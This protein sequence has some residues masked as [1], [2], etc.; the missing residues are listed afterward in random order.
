MNLQLINMKKIFI[1]LLIVASFSANAQSKRKLFGLSLN[2][3]P[4]LDYRVAIG[5]V[6]T[7]SENMTMQQLLDF[8]TLNLNVYS[9]TEVD[10][11]F[12]NYLSKTNLIAYTPTLDTHPAT[13]KY[14]DEANKGQVSGTSGTTLLGNNRIMHWFTFTS[15]D[16]GPQVVPFPFPFPNTC[17]NVV[18]SPGYSNANLILTKDNFTYDRDNTININQTIYVQAIGR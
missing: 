8:T 9:K 16:D 12:T 14:A 10:N 18:L 11:L 7:P 2:A 6:G 1:L 15:N 4:V 3:T 5:K 13:K 17:D